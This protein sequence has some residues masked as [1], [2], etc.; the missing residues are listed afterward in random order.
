MQLVLLCNEEVFSF[1]GQ[2][3]I[4]S[5]LLADL[6]DLEEVGFETEDDSRLKG[7]L[8]AIS[9]D[10]L[11]SHFSRSKYFCRYCLIDRDTF[12]KQPEKVGPKR[13]IENYRESV[14]QLG[15]D[16]ALVNRIKFDSV[17]NNL[18]HFHVCSPG[19]PPCLGHYLF[20]GV[21]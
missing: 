18:K 3:T 10:N 6:K 17:F 7:A 11:E 9:G 14:E 16:Q 2:E 21:V 5:P 1:F 4:F 20:E 12:Q 8:V 13:T 19:L 15:G